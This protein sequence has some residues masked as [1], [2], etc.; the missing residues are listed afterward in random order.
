ML[1]E[2]EVGINKFLFYN[3][4]QCNSGITTVHIENKLHRSVIDVPATTDAVID[5]LLA[6]PPVTI[7][8]HQDNVTQISTV[9]KPHI[10]HR[11]AS[12]NTYTTIT[13]TVIHQTV[14]I[15]WR[16]EAINVG[17]LPTQHINP[18]NN[19]SPSNSNSPNTPSAVVEPTEKSTPPSQKFA[20]LRSWTY[21][22]LC[23]HTNFIHTRTTTCT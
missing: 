22:C 7:A 14:S 3:V 19:S 5:S 10:L 4:I 1:N 2:F 15:W 11:H 18:F 20:S 23:T 9:I 8:T 12:N 6:L 13:Y 21:T 16:L 17:G